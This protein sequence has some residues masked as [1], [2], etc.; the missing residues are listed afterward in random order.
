MLRVHLSLQCD[1]LADEVLGDP[2]NDSPALR[3]IV[4]IYLSSKSVPEA[5]T[6]LRFRRRRLDGDLT[7]KWFA[8]ISAGCGMWP[9]DSLDRRSAQV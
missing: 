9:A 1:V 8:E 3:E 2:I 7:K 5:S 6:G 4:A